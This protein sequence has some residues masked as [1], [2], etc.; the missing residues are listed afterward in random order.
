[1][2]A[3]R[4]AKYLAAWTEGLCPPGG[5]SPNL[6]GIYESRSLLGR[7]E[8][9]GDGSVRV[10]LPSRTGVVLELQDKDGRPVVRM[11]EEHQLGPG[12]RITMGVPEALY[13]AV[14]GSCHGSISGRELDVAVTPDALTGASRSA[15]MSKLTEIGP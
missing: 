3:F 7:A 13:N 12:E 9:A 4:S 14:C 5:C 11:G 8:L 6:N 2:Q 1:V 15:S 10:R